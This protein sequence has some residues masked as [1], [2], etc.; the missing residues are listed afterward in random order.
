MRASG[1]RLSAPYPLV[2]W[3]LE[4]F[5][6]IT[7]ADNLKYPGVCLNH[8]LPEGQEVGQA[9]CI[10]DIFQEAVGVPFEGDGGLQPQR[11]HVS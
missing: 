8:L 2:L 11:R 7:L 3:D 5:D 9:T 10:R 4:Q 1:W 6:G